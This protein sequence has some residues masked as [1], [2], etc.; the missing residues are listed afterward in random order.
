M[1]N[2]SSSKT[3]MILLTVALLVTAIG[4][5]ISLDK[6]TSSGSLLTGF[7]T[8][9]QTG[10]SNLSISA[11]TAITNQVSNID[12]GA[13]YVNSTCSVC[14][15]DSDVG[16]DNYSC[17]VGFNN[18][19]SGFL[20]ENTG[21]INVSV[22][23]SCAGNCTGPSFIGGSYPLFQLKTTANSAA[24]QGGESGT[25]DSA[26]SCGG[27]L[28]VTAY[29]NITT[30]GFWLCG[31]NST[32]NGYN[33]SY[34]DAADAFVVDINVTIPSDLPTQGERIATFTFVA[35]SSG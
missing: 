12:F 35:Y 21:N 11:S 24:S 9:N 14:R 32:T 31:D 3:V 4:T 13:G 8:A 5:I 26:V 20:L 18:V 2:A 30:N 27:R 22:N 29:R 10:T 23:Y 7:A 17:C 19:T 16:Q 1:N 28:N 15:M 25:A 33:L 6:F 34:V